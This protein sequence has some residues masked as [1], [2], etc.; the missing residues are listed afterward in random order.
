MNIESKDDCEK[1][2]EVLKNAE[3]DEMKLQEEEKKLIDLSKI[4]DEQ[5]KVVMSTKNKLCNEV[6]KLEIEK[7]CYASEFSSVKVCKFRLLV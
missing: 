1:Q 4:M 5:W 2:K 6:D 3:Y 7:N